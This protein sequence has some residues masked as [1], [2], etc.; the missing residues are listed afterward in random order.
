M[1]CLR[2]T[3]LRGQVPK[4]QLEFDPEIEKTARKNQ[5]KKREEK[6]KQGQAKGES[7]N[8]LNSHNQTEFQMA[9]NR[10][11]PPRRTLGDYAMQQGPRHFSSI[12]IPPATKS[13]EMKPT[14]LSLIN[15]HQFT[16]MDHED[17]YTHLS[18][19]YEL[20]GTMGFEENDIESV[21]LRLFPFSLAGKAKEWLK[22]HPNQSLSS[23]NDVEEKF[24]HRFFPLSRYIKAKSD[25]S[26][27]RQGPEE[28][29]CEAWERFKMIL[30]R[31]PNHGFED[32]AQ[33]NIFHNGLRPDT[34][35]ILDAAA[36]GTMMSVDAEQATRI[37][38]ALASTDY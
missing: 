23:W 33:L 4:D 31:C 3:L 10:Q 19:F 36:G 27:F 24:L 6:K 16:G 8:T 12:A 29:F 34:K 38:D 22:S 5:S 14:F 21:Y 18:T 35:M 30:R 2:H 20:V 15:T 28:P 17:P 26:T 13:L 32:I 1:S 37:I 7:S 25:I 9:E 11:N